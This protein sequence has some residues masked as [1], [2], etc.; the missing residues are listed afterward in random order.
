MTDVAKYI[1]EKDEN[2]DMLSSLKKLDKDFLEEIMDDYG[3]DTVKELAD[4][5]IEMTKDQIRLSA[6]DPLSAAFFNVLIEKEDT[7]EV[8]AYDTDIEDFLV[9][10]YLK[11]DYINYYIP[12]EIKKLIKKYFK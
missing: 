4:Y 2:T 10:L 7:K 8:A 11:D 9:F 12:D 6:K 5:L 1:I 3:C